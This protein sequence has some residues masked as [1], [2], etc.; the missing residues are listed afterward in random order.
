MAQPNGKDNIPKL[1]ILTFVPHEQFIN[2]A[3]ES[4]RLLRCRARSEEGY[5][6]YYIIILSTWSGLGC[7]EHLLI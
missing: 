5:S 4:I 3:A 1:R 2:H 6:N 7:P